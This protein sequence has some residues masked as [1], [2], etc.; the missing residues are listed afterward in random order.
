MR[1]YNG[2]NSDS[3]EIVSTSLQ[4]LSPVYEYLIRDE[5]VSNNKC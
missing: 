1:S 4:G 5:Q 2:K 3:E